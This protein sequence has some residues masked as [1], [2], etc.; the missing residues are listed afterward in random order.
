[1]PP[2]PQNSKKASSPKRR[3]L[4]PEDFSDIR[5]VPAKDR[6]WWLKLS[7]PAK[8][9][10]AER[11]RQKWTDDETE[12]LVLADPDKADYYELGAAMGRSPGALRTR[13]SQMIHLLRD[14]YGYVGK[15]K[16]YLEQPREFHKWADIGQ[17]FATLQR[18]GFFDLPVHEQFA[19]ARHLKQ[20]SGGWRGDGTDEVLREQRVQVEALQARINR[21][22]R[23]G[24]SEAA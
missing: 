7:E 22:R 4:L 24:D 11:H 2:K 17:V 10:F 16:A 19:K 15:A 23:K 20:P 12:R 9:R 1:M 8:A 21:L 6:D 14:E 13:R 18:L 5:L 3:G